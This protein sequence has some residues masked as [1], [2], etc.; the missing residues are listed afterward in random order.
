MTYIGVT[1][2]IKAAHSQM[3]LDLL[4]AT[5]PCRLMIGALATAKSVR[6]I[7]MRS[8]WQNQTPP[9][10]ELANVFVADPRLLNLVHYSVSHDIESTE[11]LQDLISL[12]SH[13][14]DACHGFQIND[15]W[16]DIKILARYRD[17]LHLNDARARVIILQIPDEAVSEAGGTPSAVATRLKTYEPFIDGIL[18]DPSG[19]RGRPFDTE[20][21]RDFIT[22]IRSSG[23]T[24][25]VGL[26]GGLGPDSLNLV[27]PLLKTYPELSFDAQGKIHN[28]DGT[29][30]EDYMKLYVERAFALPR[31]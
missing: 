19:G 12:T 1:G 6:G 8:Y 26:A 7:A 25:G 11:T 24:L 29:P 15:C 13:A 28:N 10:N 17:W 27:A 21:A 22:S 16:P 31:G 2:I 9:L 30:N 4:P 14:G 3:L 5:P 18:L 20:R 23:S